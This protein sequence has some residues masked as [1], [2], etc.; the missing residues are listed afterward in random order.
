MTTYDI[1]R[2]IIMD[3]TLINMTTYDIN[4]IIIMDITLI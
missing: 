4:E 3:I 2:I 1:N